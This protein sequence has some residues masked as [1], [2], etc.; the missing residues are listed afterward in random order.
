M[1]PV[2]KAPPPPPPSLLPL[3]PSTTRASP[4]QQAKQRGGVG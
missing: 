1:L 2:E 4:W 3:H